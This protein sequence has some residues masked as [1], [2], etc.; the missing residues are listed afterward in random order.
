MGR[1]RRA[2]T[3][4]ILCLAVAGC[5]GTTVDPNWKRVPPPTASGGTV[6]LRTAS[7]CGQGWLLAGA[8]LHEGRTQPAAWTG[9]GTRWAPSSL[10]GGDFYSRQAVI[11]TAACKGTDAVML[12]SKAGGAHGL[13]RT[14]T[15]TGSPTRLRAVTT[16]FETF[17]GP[18]AL[19]VGDVTAGGDGFGLAGTRSSGA[20][21]WTAIPGSAFEIH[22]RVTGLASSPETST[23]AGSTVFWRG[24][25]VVVGALLDESDGR[26]R[27]AAFIQ[28]RGQWHH[29]ALTSPQTY[30]V[31]QRVVATSERLVAV[32]MV[33]ERFGS[34]S[35][36]DAEHWS[37]D[38]WVGAAH[39]VDTSVAAEVRSLTPVGHGAVAVID[40]GTEYSVWSWD[41][42]WGRLATPP[43]PQPADLHDC[44]VSANGPR[45]LLAITNDSGAA[46]WQWDTDP[47]QGA[48]P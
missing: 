24:R 18:D 13:P 26:Q 45:L 42:G 30:S 41:A 7:P 20:A 31:A 1:V 3:V 36:T 17:G 35:S 48:P 16:P 12:G 47:T 8:A 43:L 38:G 11:D 21:Y 32:G 44:V 39:W 4:G 2:V 33:G 40:D 5:S 29:V 46:L 27:A 14:T 10:T 19:S 22:E 25:W 9:D 15:W 34:W 28:N 23:R 37:F 6:V